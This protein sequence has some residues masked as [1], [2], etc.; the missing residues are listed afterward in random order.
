MA[1]SPDDDQ[2]PG[3]AP[4]DGVRLADLLA[5]AT[6]RTAVV[7]D[8][9]DGGQYYIRNWQGYVALRVNRHRAICWHR[10]V[11]KRRLL[12]ILERIVDGPDD[13]RTGPVDDVVPNRYSDIPS[14]LAPDDGGGR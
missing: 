3:N 4:D 2:P 6:Y 13:I 7:V 1:S 12:N 9:P 5:S 8:T 10:R 11:H 14:K